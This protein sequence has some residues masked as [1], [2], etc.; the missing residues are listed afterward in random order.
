[1]SQHWGATWVFSVCLVL[2]GAVTWGSST[3]GAIA[4]TEPS[5]ASL[6]EQERQELEEFREAERIREAIEENLENNGEIQRLVQSEV[7]RAFDNSTDLINI[8]LT[9]LTLLPIFAAIGLLL[10]RRSVI[11]Q[12]VSETRKQLQEE[13]ERQL[14]EEVTS[15]LAQQAKRF[16]Q[17]I[18]TLKR[19]FI[20]QISNLQSL[21][22][23]QI[24]QAID[25]LTPSPSQQD[26]VSPEVK[27]RIQE[28]TEQ[29]NALKSAAPELLLTADD[30]ATEG[31]AFY[32]EGR[33]EDALKSYDKALQLQPNN[34]TVWINRA[35][36]LRRLQ[37]CEEAIA[38]HDKALELAPNST[39][40]WY[41]KGYTLK[42]FQRYEAA[43]ACYDQTLKLDPNAFRTWDNRGSVLK[44]M[45]RY[46]ERSRPM[47]KQLKL[48]PT[49]PTP[50][51]TK[52]AA[53]P[54]GE[55]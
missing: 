39:R 33:Y 13:V 31:E 14:T 52:P 40:A 48:A 34:P 2:S 6:S 11:N 24:V 46:E 3:V 54:N 12:I 32:F 30:H 51:T 50:G 7:D 37:R 29:L 25:N 17:E 8:L 9:V 41:T 44:E 1:M 22:K 20:D 19:G 18:E 23:E 43:L 26:T 15:E 5:P 35:I 38:S 55:K 45:G 47:S 49:M 4:Q 42:T 27:R 36:T 16:N 10:L 28:L 21:F 53:M